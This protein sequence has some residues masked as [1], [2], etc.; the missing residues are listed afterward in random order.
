MSDTALEPKTRKPRFRR[1]AET[2]AFRVTEGDIAIIREIARH[3]FL[4][5]TQIAALVNRSLDRT[6]DRLSLL[7]HA[8]YVDRPR[9]QLDRF[10]TDGSAH[11]VYALANA[12]ARLLK[13][14]GIEVT[15]N[16]DLGHK[17]K[18]AL[19]PFIKHQLGIVDFHVA[20]QCATRDRRDVTLIHP[21]DI[22]ADFPDTT[23][24][25]RNPLKLKVKLS[26]RGRLQE[27]G[28]IP[29]LVFGLRFADG[30]RRCFCVE[31]DRG[32]MP[33][34]RSD[35]SQ[36]SFALK[37]RAYLAA[38]AAGQHTERYGW[39]A[40]RVLTVTTDQTRIESMTAALQGLHMPR[41]PGAKLFFFAT[42][43]QL[44]AATPLASSWSDGSGQVVSLI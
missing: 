2:P 29:D 37:M 14:F 16:L 31:I 22:V 11:M 1:A 43:D 6:N 17:N 24:S 19:R 12:G 36:T 13:S 38:H 30:S 23:R 4:R 40:F 34:T 44:A 25:D 7:F 32:T 33:V 15:A 26:E 3:R 18:S 39:K 9:A 8:G 42:R 20:L 5:S 35:N 10:P 27:F 28:L 41:G 21:E